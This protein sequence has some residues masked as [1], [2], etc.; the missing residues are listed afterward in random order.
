M[1]MLANNHHA[2]FIS[3]L[4]NDEEKLEALI[5]DTMDMIDNYYQKS[6]Q[7]DFSSLLNAFATKDLDNILNIINRI[8]ELNI[9]TYLKKRFETLR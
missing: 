1:E 2:P 8:N 7:Y 9:R 5:S 4:N 6:E 3:N